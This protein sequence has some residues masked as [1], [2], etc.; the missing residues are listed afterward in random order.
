MTED[1][2]INKVKASGILTV[3]LADFEPKETTF[4]L[5]IKAFLYEGG[6]IKEKEFKEALKSYPWENLRGK[7]V[8]VGCTEEAIIP[9]WVYMLL[10]LQLDGLASH[11]TFSSEEALKQKLWQEAIRLTD[12]SELSDKK[13]VVRANGKIPPLMYITITEK[14]SPLVKTLLFG[15]AGMP[16]V[17]FKNNNHESSYI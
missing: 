16:K 15:E 7:S 8:A 3:D 12:F 13:V 10:T 6:I 11:I 5:D 1:I 9:S 4:F 17:I 14:L 2:F